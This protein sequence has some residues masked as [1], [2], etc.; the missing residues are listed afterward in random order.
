MNKKQ[1]GRKTKAKARH[2][3]HNAKSGGYPDYDQEPP[4]LALVNSI[5][6]TTN[7][8]DGAT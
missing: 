5:Q 7:K 6:A 2:Q 3:E 1:V 8:A 4:H